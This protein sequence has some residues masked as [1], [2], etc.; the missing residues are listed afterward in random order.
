VVWV[1]RDDNQP[2]GLTG[3]S[4]AL[5]IWADIMAGIGASEFHPASAEGLVD[6]E[7]EYLS[8]MRA[9]RECADTV[10]VPVPVGSLLYSRQDCAPESAWQDDDDTPV[11]RGLRWLKRTLGRD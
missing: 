5:P 8:G 7:L 3:A 4:G 10:V 1:G 6:V 9:R 11:E 2:T